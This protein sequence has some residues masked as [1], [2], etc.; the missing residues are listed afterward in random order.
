MVM[1]E[2]SAYAPGDL[3]AYEIP[4]RWGNESATAQ[5]ITALLR[6]LVTE[7]GI[8]SSDRI[9]QVMGMLLV[10]VDPTALEETA[11]TMDDRALGILRCFAQPYT[12]EKPRPLLRGFCFLDEDRLRLYLT[13]AEAPGAIAVDVRP[14]NATT[15]L[16][17]SLPS[18]LD[19]EQYWTDDDSDPHCTHVVNLTDW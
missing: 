8:Y 17:A 14:A 2:A 15:A 3:I 16:L 9:S 12:D 5:D 19:E 6:T 10:R 7:T 13:T 11:S 4:L 1:G 18:L